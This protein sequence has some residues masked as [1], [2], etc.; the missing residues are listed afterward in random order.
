MMVDARLREPP[1]KGKA[2][3]LGDAT[4]VIQ[5]LDDVARQ[6]VAILADLDHAEL[7]RSM[8][9]TTTSTSSCR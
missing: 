1:G 8:P 2:P 6:K 9:T 7:N 4:Q 5:A 3:E